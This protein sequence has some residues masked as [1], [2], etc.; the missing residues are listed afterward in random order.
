MKGLRSVPRILRINKVDGYRVSCLFNNGES[1]VIDF[2]KLFEDV[3]Q[4]QK[5]DPAFALLQ[6]YEAFRQLHILGNTIGWENTGMYAEDEEGR[7][8]FYPYDL[9]PLVLYE[10]SLPDPDS[11]PGIGLMIKQ[12]RMDA[13]LTQEQLAKKSGTS[14]HYIS[15]V[16]NDKADIELLTLKKI[17]EA[18]LGRRLQIEIK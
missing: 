9:D 4:V 6:D 1:R 11:T 17:I 10:N 15:R 2:Q 16:E 12:A 13:G 18:G 7:R 5:G 3:F 8:V 14:K